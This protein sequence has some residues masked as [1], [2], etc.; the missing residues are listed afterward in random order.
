MKLKDILTGIDVL[1]VTADPALD[2]A[3]ISYDSRRTL[4]GGLFVAVPGFE[5]DG[6]RFIGMAV[7][8]GAAAVLC[9]R[10]PEDGTPFVRVADARLALAQVSCNFYR[11]PGDSLTLIGVTGTNGKTTTSVLIK[12]M[13]EKGIGATV[14][15]IGT[16]RHMIGERVIPAEHTTPESCDLQK[17][18][19]AMADAGCTHVVMEVSSHS[20]VLHR[21]A[22][23]T[24]EVGIFTNLTQDHLDFHV[25]MEKYA[26]A[27]ALL[28]RR[29]R[30]AAVNLDDGWASVMAAAAAGPVMTYSREKNEA[31]LVAKDIKLSATGVKFC[32][33]TTGR[34][35]RVSLGIPGLFSV[36]NALAVIAC[37]LLL[38]MDLRD[39]AA[40]LETAQGVKGRV[41][42]VPDTG[43]FSILID[44]AHTPD[45]LESLLRSL[46][47]V[48][49]GR[50]VVLF[51]CG[52]DRDRTK[53]PLMGAV[54]EENADFVIVTSDN[55][56]TEAPGAIIEDILAG[57]KGKKS[58]RMVI[59]DRREAIGWAIENNKPGDLL[60]LAGKGHEDYQIVGKEKRHMDEREIVA[61]FLERK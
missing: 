58:G 23:L 12:H 48:T 49:S 30:R 41:E 53:R 36:N 29:C 61:Y 55:P 44:Y 59:E 35:E 40:A 22:G 37:G 56:R 10:A 54:A 19:R 33:L 3:D 39:C 45:A 34:L 60:I 20:L 28:F 8:N 5:T 24:F 25:T 50:L 32:A 47:Q 2:I 16:N 26:E 4:P 11:H 42:V 1:E 15:L 43:D 27:K 18:L 57:M 7:Q 51:G 52:G 17:L 38:G 21:V 14:G 46:R 9:E 13:L 6:H 31:D